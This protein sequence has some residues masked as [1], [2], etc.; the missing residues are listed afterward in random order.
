MSDDTLWPPAPFD[1]AMARFAEHDAWYKGDTATLQSIYSGGSPTATHVRSGVSYK[2]GVVGALSKMFWGQPIV[3]DEKRMKMHIPV[4]S[5]LAT[6]SADLLFAE[7]PKVRFVKPVDNKVDTTDPAAPKVK[8]V[9]A[10]Q[11]RLDTIMGSDQAHAELLKSGEYSAAL[12]GS[13]L[14]VVWDAAVKDHVWFR[15]YAADCAIPEFRYGSMVACTLWTEYRDADGRDVFRLLERHS[16]GTISYT[17]HKGTDR[18]LGPTVSLFDRAETMHYEALRTQAELE[19]YAID[20]ELR[21]NTVTVAT[22]VDKLA[23]VYY[24]NMLPQRDW[25]KLGDLANLGRSDFAGIED[26][27]D[28]IDQVWSSLMRDV[29]NG[30]GRITV[31]DSFLEQGE[32]GEGAKFDPQ[33]QVYAGLNMLGKSGDTL[34]GSIE[35]SQ[36]EIRVDEHLTALEA[37]TRAI[38]STSGYSPAH[39]G[40][41]DGGGMRTATEIAADLS[42]SERTRD[43]KAMYVKP[44]LAELAQVALAI[45]GVVFP[46]KGGK[47]YEELPDIEFAPVSQIDVEK[48]ARSIQMLDMARAAATKTRV[49]MAHPDWEDDQVDEE[50]KDILR[51]QGTPAPDPATFTG[52]NT[53]EVANA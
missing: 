10:G 2:G 20:P 27:F 13:Y 4:P 22:G 44:A 52:D 47:F 18:D 6:L 26:L 31:P 49:R 23:V 1:I 8:W 29:E 30:A 48:N 34:S 19:T 41:K 35:V 28:K 15:A 12:G 40:L 11:E 37:L 38:A 33:R 3:E 50:V 5:D 17:L 9:H 25:R 45:D 46:G 24:P 21:S 39:L 14:A 7:A 36:F 16:K 43:K 32:R 53:Q 51:E 42:D